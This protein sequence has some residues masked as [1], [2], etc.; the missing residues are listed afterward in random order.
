M[1]GMKRLITLACLAGMLL[2]SAGLNPT[3][4][5]ATAANADAGNSIAFNA[6]G[7][8]TDS[9]DTVSNAVYRSGITLAGGSAT[10]PGEL[11]YNAGTA[12]FKSVSIDVTFNKW[13][14]NYNHNDLAVYEAV[15]DNT[16]GVF[17]NTRPIAMVRQLRPDL[18]ANKDIMKVTYVSEPLTPGTRYL[19]IVTPPPAFFQDQNPSY[20][21]EFKLDAITF[22][23]KAFK[24]YQ[25]EYMVDTLSD[26]SRFASGADTS[27]LSVTDLTPSSKI[28]DARTFAASSYIERKDA[29]KLDLGMTYKALVGKEFNSVYVEGYFNFTPPGYF[30]VWTS[31]DGTTYVNSTQ[32]SNRLNPPFADN[33]QWLPSVIQ[34]KD[35]PTGTQFVQ[36]RLPAY[37]SNQLWGM[38][39]PRMTRVALGYGDPGTGNPEPVTYKAETAIKYTGAPISIDGIVELDGAGNPVGEWQGALYEELKGVVDAN[40]D[41]HSAKVYF[42][43][44]YDNLYVGAKI[45]DPTPMKNTNTGS[46]IWAGDNLEIF[47]GTEDL[48]Y[49]LYPDKKLTML[50]TDV[51][52]V[53][54]GGLD[55][56][57]QFYLNQNG[58][59]SYPNI[60]LSVNPD[61]DLKGYTIEAS[62]PLGVL[63][64]ANPWDSKAVIM[65]SVLNDGAMPKRGQYGWTTTDEASKTNRSLWGLAALEPVSSPP[66]EITVQAAVAEGSRL[67]TVTGQTYNVQAKDVTLLVYDPNGAIAYIDQAHSNGQGVYTF[68]FLLNS[69][70]FG[71]GLYTVLAGGDGVARPNKAFFTV[72]QALP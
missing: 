16:S 53:L 37:A 10:G 19:R 45:K 6:A 72:P 14:L 50:P 3:V 15:Y 36:I 2:A 40:G 20:F 49:R 41:S 66:L 42:K 7:A 35:L 1:R 17:T 39:H 47:L 12:E 56:G 52:V 62:I 38:K 59:F 30:E 27:N 11:I 18:M 22:T 70:L 34:I 23:S 69:D 63:G 29:T 54:S 9:L 31:L 25:N 46:N 33:S 5:G 44:D 24:A 43:Y 26:F 57:P 68:T 32:S 61:A 55:N 48:D 28:W 64:I 4:A 58:V 65:N 67:V 8:F 60:D 71:N 21:A 51:Q 13:L